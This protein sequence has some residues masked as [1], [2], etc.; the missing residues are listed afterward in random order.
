MEKFKREVL[1]FKDNTEE[2]AENKHGK[3][4]PE[5]IIQ[6]RYLYYDYSNNFLIAN[7]KWRRNN[8]DISHNSTWVQN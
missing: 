8:F 6:V 4:E 1:G 3:N 7:W 2:E 5:F